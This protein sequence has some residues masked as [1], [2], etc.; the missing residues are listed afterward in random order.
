MGFQKNFCNYSAVSRTLNYVAARRFP[1]TSRHTQHWHTVQVLSPKRSEWE[2]RCVL[3][4]R[5]IFYHLSSQTFARLP[6]AIGEAALFPLINNA[7]DP[8]S[9]YK[10]HLRF[11]R[12]NN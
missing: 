5:Y 12:G 11:Y 1:G 7:D 8:A 3:Q 6:A 4:I 10:D 2:G 9:T